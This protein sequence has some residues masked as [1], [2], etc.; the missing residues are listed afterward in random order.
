MSIR[1]LVIDDEPIA[2]HSITRLLRGD[3]DIDLVGEYGDGASALDAIRHLAPDL[4]FLDI[5]MPEMSG[6]D[7]VASIDATRMPATVFVTAYERYAVRA[8]E[9]NAVDYLVKPFQPRTVRA[10]ADAGEAP[11]VGRDRVDPGDAGAGA[12]RARRPAQGAGLRA[13]DPGSG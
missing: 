6:I 8:F 7:V 1:T 9:A 5:Q 10:D 12:A 11:A 4:I 2:R 3:P 13:A